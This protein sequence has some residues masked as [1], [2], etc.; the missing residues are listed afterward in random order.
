M[1][2]VRPVAQLVERLLEAKKNLRLARELKR[3]DNFECI[4]LDDIE[5]EDA[6]S[7]T[8]IPESTRRVVRFRRAGQHIGG[9]VH[10]QRVSR[11]GRVPE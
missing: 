2:H 7:F 6:F 5:R 10:R 11:L 1:S 4:A 8:M 3:L 9:P